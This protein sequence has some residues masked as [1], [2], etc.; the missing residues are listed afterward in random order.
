MPN[1]IAFYK[2]TTF[3]LSI[4]QLKDIWVVST[5]QQL[6]NLCISF[7]MDMF[8]FLLVIYLGVELLGHTIT[9]WHFEDLQNCFPQRLHHFTFPPSKYEGSSFSTSLPIL[10]VV[11][12]TLAGFVNVKWYLI[13]VSLSFLM[14]CSNSEFVLNTVP[15]LDIMLYHFTLLIV[16]FDEQKF[17]VL[18]KFISF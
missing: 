1:N 11:F 6:W 8:S 13:V 2:C 7:Y 9:V 12:F 4:H 3:C 10:V 18:V 17:I 5:F 14:I 16:C 15:L